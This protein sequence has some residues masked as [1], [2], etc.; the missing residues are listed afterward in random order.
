LHGNLI[1]SSHQRELAGLPADLTIGRKDICNSRT[2]RLKDGALK[3]GGQ[4]TTAEAIKPTGW[5]QSP[6]KNDKPW[7]ILTLTP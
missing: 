4:K 1:E 5:D 6:I 2:G 7:Q 3:A